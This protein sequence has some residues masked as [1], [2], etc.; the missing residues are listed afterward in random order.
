MI[1][2]FR[3]LHQSCLHSLTAHYGMVDQDRITALPILCRK[4]LLHKDSTGLT[5]ECFAD[6]E[7]HLKTC[8]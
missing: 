8:E 2:D 1:T 6:L 7:T 5:L 4:V 3:V